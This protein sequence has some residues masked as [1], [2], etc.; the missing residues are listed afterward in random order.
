MS[1]ILL[2]AGGT[3]AELEQIME[4]AKEHES[5]ERIVIFRKEVETKR[6]IERILEV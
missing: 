5:I 1:K 2:V 6:L 3:P 4:L